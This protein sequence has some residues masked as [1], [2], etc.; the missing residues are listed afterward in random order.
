MKRVRQP[1][2]V[3]IGG[4]VRLMKLCK[5]PAECSMRLRAYQLLT[6]DTSASIDHYKSYSLPLINQS[7]DGYST[8]RAGKIEVKV[9]DSVK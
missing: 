7:A 4:E 3:I 9:A 5:Q 8:V 1:L 2:P 6:R